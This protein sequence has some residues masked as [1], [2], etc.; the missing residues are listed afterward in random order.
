MP[1]HNF[2]VS[3]LY[4]AY[5]CFS[6]YIHNN[7]YYAKVYIYKLALHRDLDDSVAFIL[8]QLVCFVDF[9]E[10]IGVCDQ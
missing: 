9:C 7:N 6:F 1:L 8:K 2:S 4:M 10:R 3:H 5:A